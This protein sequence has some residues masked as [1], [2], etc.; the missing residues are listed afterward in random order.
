MKDMMPGLVPAAEV[1][2]FRQK[3]PKPVALGVVR[4]MPSD[5]R[6]IQ[7][8]HNSV[9]SNSAALALGSVPRLSHAEWAEPMV[10]YTFRFLSSHLALCL[11]WGWIGRYNC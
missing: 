4:G 8:R 1:L 3:D 9:R 5:A 2:L 7:R 10:E 11:L 6:R